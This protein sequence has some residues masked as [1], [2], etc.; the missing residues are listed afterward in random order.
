MKMVRYVWVMLV[1]GMIFGGGVLAQETMPPTLCTQEDYLML[2]TGISNLIGG[3]SDN[4]LYDPTYIM[5]QVRRALETYQLLCNQKFTSE[6]HPNG[7]IGPLLF[8][9]TLYEV[10]F[11]GILTGNIDVGGSVTMEELSGDCGFLN[12]MAITSNDMDE[13]D[14]MEFGENCEAMIEVH[15]TGA[16][17]L[18]FVKIK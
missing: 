6:T 5:Y 2:Q 10:T 18:S 16:W 12:M 4:A 17:E 14:L 9:G 1:V 7:I 8:D 13:T 11:V 15:R 3:L